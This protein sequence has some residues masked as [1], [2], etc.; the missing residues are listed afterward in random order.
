MYK[1]TTGIMKAPLLAV[2]ARDTK[3]PVVKEELALMTLGKF[4]F[5]ITPGNHDTMF[6]HP[7][8]DK[9]AEIIRRNLKK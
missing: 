7:N 8:V 5:E 4:T 6:E 3:A 2:K 1:R 9:L